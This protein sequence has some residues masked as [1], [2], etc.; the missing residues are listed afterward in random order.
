MPSQIA[1]VVRGSSRRSTKAARRTRRARKMAGM[2]AQ[3]MIAR[4]CRSHTAS[5]PIPVKASSALC[6]LARSRLS[7]GD[8]KFGS[9]SLS[10]TV[11]SALQ[12]TGLR[13]SGMDG[14][15]RELYHSANGDRWYLACDSAASRSSDTNPIAL[16]AARYRI[17]RSEPFLASPAK[18]QR[19]RSC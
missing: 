19:S 3:Q 15:T 12:A 5:R 2:N 6:S 7:R 1:S 14:Q 13:S 11:V 18:V 4:C 8:A 9:A 17:S 16:Q 10:A